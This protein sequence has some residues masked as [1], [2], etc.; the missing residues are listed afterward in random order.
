MLG[1]ASDIFKGIKDKSTRKKYKATEECE[2]FGLKKRRHEQNKM[3]NGI[4]ITMFY[5]FISVNTKQRFRTKIHNIKQ[6]E[7]ERKVNQNKKTET[8]VQRSNGNTEVPES[9]R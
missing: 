2:N 6:E 8:Q 7:Q 5:I 9:K 4:Y 3:D 1:Q